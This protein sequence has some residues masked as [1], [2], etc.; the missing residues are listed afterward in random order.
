MDGR[1][2][3]STLLEELKAR[4]VGASDTS[5]ATLGS[6][7]K[8]WQVMLLRRVS[9]RSHSIYILMWFASKKLT[10]ILSGALLSLA[11]SKC[12][13]PCASPADTDVNRTRNLIHTSELPL[14]YLTDHFHMPKHYSTCPFT[15]NH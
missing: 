14:F 4:S 8:H 15:Y 10:M 12:G 11:V 1:G 7:G 6:G 2:A 5:V 13:R 9:R 3:G